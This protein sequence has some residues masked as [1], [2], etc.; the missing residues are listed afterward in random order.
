MSLT[1]E[2][3]EH[4]A[5]L[6]RLDL[7]PTELDSYQEQ[8]SAILDYADRLKQVDTSGIAPTSSVLPPHTVLRED[9]ARPGLS[10]KLALQNTA[11]QEQSQFRVPPVLDES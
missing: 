5:H 2:E 11:R 10:T 1:R 6:A 8:L 3:V 7:S 4:I 9:V